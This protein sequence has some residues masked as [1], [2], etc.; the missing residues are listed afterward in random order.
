MLR[1]W[2]STTA[3]ECFIVSTGHGTS[4]PFTFTG[5]M[6]P[7]LCVA[8]GITTPWQV[9]EIVSADDFGTRLT[10]EE[11]A[12]PWRTWG[13]VAPGEVGGPHSVCL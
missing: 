12:P 10:A 7:D 4:G 1:T 5:V 2:P 9:A 8:L 11:A 6:L 13:C 3:E